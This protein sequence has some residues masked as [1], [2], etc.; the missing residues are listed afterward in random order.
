MPA[1]QEHHCTHSR[2][3]AIAGCGLVKPADD[4]IFEVLGLV[5][6]VMY[7]KS[8]GKKSK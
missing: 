8:K 3:R 6:A 5:L 4:P 2:V 7:E 1:Q